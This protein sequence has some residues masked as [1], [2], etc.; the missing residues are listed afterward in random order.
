MHGFG[1][2]VLL[3]GKRRYEGGWQNDMPHGTSNRVKT[4]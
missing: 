4:L 3:G 1:V 2:Y